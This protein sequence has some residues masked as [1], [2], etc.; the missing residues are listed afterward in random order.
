[1]LKSYVQNLTLLHGDHTNLLENDKK[2]IYQFLN[3]F[4]NSISN[5]AQKHNINGA[6][7][8]QRLQGSNWFLIYV[9]STQPVKCCFYV[10]NSKDHTIKSTIPFDTLELLKT[11]FAQTMLR[12][13]QQTLLQ[14]KDQ[15][16][17][18]KNSDI[19]LKDISSKAKIHKQCYIGWDI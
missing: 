3:N 13:N 6:Y 7:I 17:L 12:L 14:R 18:F 11:D 4:A 1:M 5:M 8:T 10:Y 2:I 15:P 16:M 19:L 9:D